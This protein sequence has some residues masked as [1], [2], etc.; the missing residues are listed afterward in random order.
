[1][2]VPFRLVQ[3][4]SCLIYNINIY[5]WCN[6]THSPGMMISTH[7][8]SVILTS[9]RISWIHP[10]WSLNLMFYFYPRN[11]IFYLLSYNLARDNWNEFIFVNRIYRARNCTLKSYVMPFVVA[12]ILIRVSF[13]CKWVD[14]LYSTALKSRVIDNI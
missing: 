4:D 8:H 9:I 14:F 3:L 2:Y 10:T 11:N 1:M 7:P 12:R 5:I 6:W 13:F